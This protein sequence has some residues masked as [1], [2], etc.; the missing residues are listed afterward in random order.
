VQLLKADDALKYVRRKG[1]TAQGKRRRALIRCLPRTYGSSVMLLTCITATHPSAHS[2]IRPLCAGL[3]LQPS[4]HRARLPFAGYLRPSL[5]RRWC[6]AARKKGEHTGSGAPAP[7]ACN[8]AFTAA[9][10]TYLSIVSTPSFAMQN[11]GSEAAVTAA[12]NAAAAFSGVA[13]GS[14]ATA[15]AAPADGA[16][17]SA[18]VSGRA[19]LE[20]LFHAAVRHQ[21]EVRV[22]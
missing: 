15:A 17:A 21:V 13:A 1:P 9:H 11:A 7:C 10:N 4:M 22:G 16:G 20:R 14:G 5:R 6:V 8:V 3:A 19:A 12:A 18:Y 2:S